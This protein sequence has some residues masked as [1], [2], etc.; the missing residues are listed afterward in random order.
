MIVEKIMTTTYSN[1]TRGLVSGLLF[2]LLVPLSLLPFISQSEAKELCGTTYEPTASTLKTI[3]LESLGIEVDIPTN[4][5]I[6]INEHDNSIEILDPNDF[7]FVQCVRQGG[8]GGR[9]I[10][11]QVIQFENRHDLVALREEAISY[12]QQAR[13][14]GSKIARL[15]EYNNHDTLSGYI[16][17]GGET[18][19]FF[20][21]SFDNKSQ[22]LRVSI[23]CD[24][25]VLPEEIFLL[26]SRIRL[27][28]D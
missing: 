23:A 28:T 19:V 21:G 10:C 16:V 14:N 9:G 26:L 12:I 15:I 20:M 3:R 1:S 11:P 27:I 5:E 17:V 4:H 24:S 2:L 13:Q 6:I 22:A 8:V 25:Y 18:S 7:K